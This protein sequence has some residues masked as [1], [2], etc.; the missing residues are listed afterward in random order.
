MEIAFGSAIVSLLFAESPKIIVAIT[1][2]LS[3]TFGGAVV[4]FT[5]KDKEKMV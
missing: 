5:R 3:A 1:G 4:V 2:A